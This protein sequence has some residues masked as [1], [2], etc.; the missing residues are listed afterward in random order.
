MRI[1]CLGLSRWL[2][3]LISS[4]L[5]CWGL[6][7]HRCWLWCR[8]RLWLRLHLLNLLRLLL[9]LHLHRLWLR[10]RWHLRCC[11][12]GLHWSL[13]WLRRCVLGLLILSGHRSRLLHLR[14]LRILH[15][16]GSCLQ[17]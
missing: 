3:L 2:R 9:L 1:L 15:L 6:L 10:L 11:I 13:L 4:C 5:W 7:R 17:F 8:H 16:G 12:F 14:R